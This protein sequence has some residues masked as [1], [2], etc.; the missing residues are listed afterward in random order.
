MNRLFCFICGLLAGVPS[1]GQEA[2]S[3]MFQPV[4]V[5]LTPE[6]GMQKNLTV[7]DTVYVKTGTEVTFNLSLTC[8]SIQAKNVDKGYYRLYI[9]KGGE[10][11]EEF[12]LKDPVRMSDE[13][14]TQ[15]RFSTTYRMDDAT[16]YN[17]DGKYNI[18]DSDTVSTDT[19]DIPAIYFHALKPIVSASEFEDYYCILGD[20]VEL[21]PILYGGYGSEADWKFKWSDGKTD[22]SNKLT[23]DSKGEKDCS[24]IATNLIGENVWEEVTIPFKVFVF[25]EPDLE[26]SYENHTDL[27]ERIIDG[28]NYIERGTCKFKL[29]LNCQTDLAR[30]V[31]GTIGFPWS[32]EKDLPSEKTIT[33]NH[34]LDI[35]NNSISGKASWYIERTKR[36]G[37]NED[38][39]SFKT[40]SEKTRETELADTLYLYAIEKINASLGKS[41][42]HVIVNDPLTLRP[43]VDGG[44]RTP[45]SNWKFFWDSQEGDT[46][47]T[48]T[49]EEI[50][51]QAHTFKAANYINGTEWDS[52]TVQFDIHAYEK[53]DIDIEGVTDTTVCYPNKPKFVVTGTGGN[54]DEW[55]YEWQK[56][57]KAIIGSGPDIQGVY[58]ELD[59]EED[60][61]FSVTAK[62]TF[63]SG[64]KE[65]KG[66]ASIIVHQYAQPKVYEKKVPQGIKNY[67]IDAEYGFRDSIQYGIQYEGGYMD[68][69]DM[70]VFNE[71]DDVELDSM[72]VVAAQEE[73]KTYRISL[74]NHFTRKDGA[75]ET[76][77]DKNVSTVTINGLK[78][79]DAE[80]IPDSTDLY[81]R[82]SITLRINHW[83]G[84][85]DKWTFEWKSPT[86][87]SISEGGY[88][89]QGEDAKC[90]YKDYTDPQA[91]GDTPQIK[92]VSVI[93]KSYTDGEIRSFERHINL[94]VWYEIE[95][96]A[97][98]SFVGSAREGNRVRLSVDS[99]HGGYGGGWRYAWHESGQT[100][101]L[102]DSLT[103][104]VVPSVSFTGT[105]RE[106]KEIA[107]EV[108]VTNYY[109]PTGNSWGGRRYDGNK[110]TV[111]HRPETPLKL[112]RKGNGASR[113]MIVDTEEW[114]NE[115]ALTANG[116]KFWF[117]YTNGQGEDVALGEPTP[118]LYFKFD[119]D[120]QYWQE[121]QYWVCAVWDYDDGARVTSG[122]CYMPG[123]KTF[124]ACA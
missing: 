63:D 44:L 26:I 58:D 91:R 35:G 120:N 108:D 101:T 16:I 92:T 52:K 97:M 77:Y 99:P 122:K 81:A 123:G 71:T 112:R 41:D 39:L 59:E 96:G 69:W 75:I 43:S 68:G 5:E 80:I 34:L 121:E 66:S 95:Y 104:D 109:G 47:K 107:Y 19:I 84:L 36:T 83:G 55:S 8:D 25:E 88:N 51:N 27:L 6:M 42:Y 87:L 32:S 14:S 93:A 31:K 38:N 94:N 23:L 61:T 57:G 2:D 21:S 106:K 72:L 113:T 73:Q 10:Q 45:D 60:V 33:E 62:N 17:I 98:G 103:M 90:T 89:K 22:K 100:D 53:P 78:E 3:T 29:A 50:G 4:H 111:Y 18:V 56:N 114:M 110:V 1:L 7:A 37:V 67:F 79:P 74:S 15:W 116:Y 24:L 11:P 86:T 115:T 65:W 82:H 54:K 46:V 76:W 64:E 118:H 105:G 119:N 70:K 9:S 102:S 12:V 49:L 30:K 13:D 40:E 85:D 124:S 28:V 117:G 20:E 48:F